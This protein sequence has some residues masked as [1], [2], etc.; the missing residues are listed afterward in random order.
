MKFQSFFE[1]Q[2]KLEKKFVQEG[3][4]V[5]ENKEKS[6]H[7]AEHSASL[8]DN[9]TTEQCDN[10]LSRSVEIVEPVSEDQLGSARF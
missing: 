10:S 9:E 8:V 6:E 5:E 4:V 1:R 3:D 7:E 2:K